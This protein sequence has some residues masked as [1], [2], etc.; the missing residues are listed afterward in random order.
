MCDDTQ[1]IMSVVKTVKKVEKNLKRELTY[2]DMQLIMKAQNDD[3]AF[4][5]DGQVYEVVR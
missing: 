4:E 2:K 1:R 5:I 3:C